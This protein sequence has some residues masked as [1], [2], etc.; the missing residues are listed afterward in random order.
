MTPK[1]I[2]F[3]DRLLNFGNP[4]YFSV[5]GDIGHI[6]TKTLNPSFNK[7]KDRISNVSN[8]VTRDLKFFGDL[9]HSLF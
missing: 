3:D 5:V 4:A 8:E 7:T 9:V 1:L 2:I 6:L